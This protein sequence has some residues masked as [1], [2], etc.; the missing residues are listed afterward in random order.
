M[1]VKVLCSCVVPMNKTFFILLR[2]ATASNLFSP[3]SLLGP[4]FPSPR[5]PTTFIHL[6]FIP[7]IPRIGRERTGI[8]YSD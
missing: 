7:K 3:I 6:V 2:R 4:E 8:P 1:F 5:A